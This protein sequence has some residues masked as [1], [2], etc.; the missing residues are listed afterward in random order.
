MTVVAITYVSEMF[1]TDKRGRYQAWIMT[2]GL[3]GI[4]FS[5]L[6]AGDLIPRLVYGWR[7]VFVFGALAIFMPLFSRKLEESPRRPHSHP[8]DSAF[9]KV[10]YTR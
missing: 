9:F 7:I 1:P 6:V 3:F 8:K 10:L 5:A 4:P 2:V